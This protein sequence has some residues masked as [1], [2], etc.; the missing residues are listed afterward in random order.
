MSNTGVPFGRQIRERQILSVNRYLHKQARLCT[1]THA[2][3]QAHTHT[4][5]HKSTHACTHTHIHTH[6][7][8]SMHACM[9]T[10]THTHIHT[11]THTKK[12]VNTCTYLP[13][14]KTSAR[15]SLP[16]FADQP[17]RKCLCSGQHLGQ[18]GCQ[19]GQEAEMVR[20][21]RMAQDL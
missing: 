10:H 1:H 21:P 20:G 18:V 15:A 3:T 4:H 11:H 16:S 17:G 12:H 14:Y 7:H 8:T 9:H 5:T 13:L 19:E 6:T 2:N